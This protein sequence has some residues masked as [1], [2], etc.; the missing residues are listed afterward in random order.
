MTEPEL[1]YEGVLEDLGGIS[2][3]AAHLAVGLWRVKRW[4]ERRDDVGCPRPVLELN[5]G[6]LYSKAD[7][8]AWW[9]LW[10]ATRAH[11]TYIRKEL[12]F[13]E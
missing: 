7:W 13:P 5:M 11:K 1:T 4:I 3:I 6:H 2:E 12:R 9:A 8:D 10:K